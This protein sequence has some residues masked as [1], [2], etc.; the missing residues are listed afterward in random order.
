MNKNIRLYNEQL[1]RWLVEKKYINKDKDIR[2]LDLG[3][4]YGHFYFAL[5]KAGYNNIYAMDINPKFRGCV[6]ADAT[7][8]LPFPDNFFDLII[9]RDI[10]EHIIDSKAFF[11]NQYNALMK[12]GTIIVMTPNAKYLSL[13]EFYEDYTHCMPYTEK[14]LREALELHNFD[15]IHTT[16]IRAV[17][18]L[19]KYTTK[20]FDVVYSDVYNNLLGVGVK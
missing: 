17:P 1:I 8:Q 16:T 7:K 11:N 4:G 5:K 2:I 6:K 20:A 12:G 18:L 13:G 14:S 19:W 15:F 9:S 10:A 3:S